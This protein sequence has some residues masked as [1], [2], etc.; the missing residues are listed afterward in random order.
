[1]QHHSNILIH[2]QILGQ[3]LRFI[4]LWIAFYIVYFLRDKEREE[5]GSNF[6]CE[7]RSGETEERAVLRST[8]L[9]RVEFP[10]RELRLTGLASTRLVVSEHAVPSPLVCAGR[11]SP[12]PRFHWTFNGHVVAA[13]ARLTFPAGVLRSDHRERKIE[14]DPSLPLGGGGQST[15]HLPCWSTQV[16]P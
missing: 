15:A 10:P 2:L 12:S 5:D 16:R 9:F 8:S 1:M 7:A 14:T 4:D 6:T 13:G 11:G 3:S